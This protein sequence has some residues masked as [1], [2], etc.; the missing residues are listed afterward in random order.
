MKFFNC[1]VEV[2]EVQFFTANLFRAMVIC[3]VFE[4]TRRRVWDSRA[5]H[6]E[7]RVA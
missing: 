1:N 5:N 4:S 7:W 3:E 6:L 2:C